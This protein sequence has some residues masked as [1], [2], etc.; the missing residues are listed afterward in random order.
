MMASVESVYLLHFFLLYW[1]IPEAG[2]YL[3]LEQPL[4][5]P[6]IG[7]LIIRFCLVLG[8]ATAMS[9]LTW[10]WVEQPGIRL[11]RRV[12]AHRQSR[13]ARPHSVS[14]DVPLRA[15]I[16]QGDSPDAQF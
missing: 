15:A 14:L 3:H 9:L 11:G 4:W 6:V 10:K 13:K 12:I 1:A 8:G 5:M 16:S 7:V 2:H